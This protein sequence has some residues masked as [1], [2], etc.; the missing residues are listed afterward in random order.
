M[1]PRCEARTTSCRAKS[2]SG[3]TSSA[4]RA[5]CASATATSRSAR[6]SSSARSCSRRAPA[7]PPTSSRRRCTASPTRAASA[8]RCGRKRRRAWCAPTSSTTSST[9]MPS[10]KL[11]PMGPMFRYERPQKGR[12]RQFHQ[13]DVEVFGLS[14]PAIDAE[15]IDLAWSADRDAR[16]SRRRSWSSTPSAAPS[17]GRSSRRRCSR[18]S[19]TT[20]RSCARTAS[21]ARQTNP[22]RIYD[23]KVPAD[24]P[25]IDRAAALG[26]LPLRAVR[27]ALRRRAGAPR[28]VG[29]PVADLAPA[30]PRARLLHA[31]D[32][33]GAGADA[34]RAER[35]ARRRPLRRPGEARSAGRI[36]RAS[37]SRPASS[38]WCSRCRRARGRR[39]RR[40]RS[41]SAIGDDGRAEALRLLRELRR[42]GLS[43]QME[44]EAREHARRR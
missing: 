27:D 1:I 43:A 20:C 33:R 10:A 36:G 8:S 40:G 16:R 39:P 21:G 44:F 7:K 38:G 25:I 23:C 14:D 31:D 26:R 19:A 2:R 13:L 32:V 28:R 3:S 11:Y 35:A 17:A 34:G 29:D 15:V 9:S 4:S 5:R 42:A 12:Y 41:S 24:Q 30:G 18:R 37:A 22:L 6:P